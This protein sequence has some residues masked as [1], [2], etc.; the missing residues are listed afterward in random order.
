MCR[1]ML[2]EP[3]EHPPRM[4]W[5]TQ[6]Q[7]QP[8]ALGSKGRS[9]CMCRGMLAEPHEHPPRMDWGTQ[10]QAQP[11]ALGSKGR[12]PLKLFDFLCVAKPR[13][14]T[15][16]AY[17]VG[18]Y[19]FGNAGDEHLLRQ[20]KKLI[21]AERSYVLPPRR[22]WG[23]WDVARRVP[24]VD[25]V[26]FGG[27]SLFQDKSSFLSMVYYLLILSWACLWRR[28]VR[29]LGHGFGPVRSR[30]LSR[31]LAMLL[32]HVDRLVARDSQSY[33][34]FLAL[35][36]RH[37]CTVLG[38][39]LAYVSGLK[40]DL[41]VDDGLVAVSVNGAVLQV[42]ESALSE[43][44]TE[45]GSCDFLWIAM[46]EGYDETR[47][48]HVRMCDGL[49]LDEVGANIRFRACISMRY[50]ACVWASLR[51]IPFLAVGDDPKLQALAHIFGQP[52]LSLR[53]SAQVVQTEMHDFLE[54][55]ETYRA[56]LLAARPAVLADA[57]NLVRC[58]RD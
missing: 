12:S 16:V 6:I 51:G 58:Y 15:R 45:S 34:D 46:H 9:F 14:E 27:G 52:V 1:G 31:W 32:P 21:A 37:V 23:L 26:V 40:K 20:A 22:L 33:T 28:D 19:G 44:A 55:R 4:D 36:S 2:A 24:F 38:A 57:K 18:Y 35:G 25:T 56:C 29:I 7:A 13:K 42:F 47:A 48:P 41:Y 8:Q 17:F 54:K 43:A 30:F 50:H 3:H 5:G 53:N 11:Q 39:D 49:S 10:I